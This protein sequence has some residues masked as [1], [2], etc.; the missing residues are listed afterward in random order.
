[1]AY[2]VT[3]ELQ[4]MLCDKCLIRLQAYIICVIP[5]VFYRESI[6]LFVRF[7]LR[8]CR[9]D[10]V[11]RMA[12]LKWRRVMGNQDDLCFYI[13]P[14]NPPFSKGEVKVKSRILSLP[15]KPHFL[16]Q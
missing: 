9:N 13:I 10:G 8:E 1:M 4:P 16:S 5:E 12:F 6:L 7:L 15:L 2:L 14:L 3:R 11:V